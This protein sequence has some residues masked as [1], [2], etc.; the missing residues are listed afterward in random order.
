MG[1]F[2]ITGRNN[3]SSEEKRGIEARGVLS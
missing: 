3:D 1:Y 2:A